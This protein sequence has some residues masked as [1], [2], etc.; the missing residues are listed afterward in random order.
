MSA[1]R[2]PPRDMPMVMPDGRINN[3]WYNFLRDSNEQAN[4]QGVSAFVTLQQQTYGIELAG[5]ATGSADLAGETT[6]TLT[7][8]VTGVDW[9]N[10]SNTPIDIAGYGITN[11]YTTTQVDSLLSSKANTSHTHSANDITSDTF[12]D[13]RIAQSNVTQHEAALSL[14]YEQTFTPDLMFDNASD[15][16]GSASFYGLPNLIHAKNRA[17]GSKTLTADEVIFIPFFVDRTTTLEGAVVNVSTASATSGA[18]MRVGIYNLGTAGNT[19]WTLGSLVKDLGAVAVDSTGLKTLTVSPGQA[20]TKGWYVA[21]YGSDVSDAE[22]QYIRT[23]DDSYKTYRLTS[24]SFDGFYGLTATG[25]NSEI[26]SGYSATFPNTVSVDQS[27]SDSY[28]CLF[29]WARWT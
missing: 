19:T 3:D 23:R 28:Y 8:S 27:G 9:A 21:A 16:G 22:Y 12:A 2:I 14:L 6:T 4:P 25:S 13:A 29:K 11:A 1:P 5:D 10:I 20:L 26:T 24:G 15:A 7:V 18:V 17:G